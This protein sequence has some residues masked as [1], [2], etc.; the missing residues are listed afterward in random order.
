VRIVVVVL[1]SVT[2]FKLRGLRLSLQC[3]RTPGVLWCEETSGTTNLM[4]LRHITEHIGLK[5]LRHIYIYIYVYYIYIYMYYIYMCMCARVCVYIY[6][7]CIIYVC[8][9]VRVCTERGGAYLM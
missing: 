5:I 7:K 4:T 6:I 3:C 1:T 2:L 9:Y 8:A